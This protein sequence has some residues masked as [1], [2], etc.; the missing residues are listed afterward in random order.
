M[1]AAWH[2]KHPLG[3]KPSF[4]KRLAWHLE[5]QK[6]CGCRPIPAKLLAE[7]KKRAAPKLL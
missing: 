3:P 6:H 5:H 1:N 2:E 7:M 4:E